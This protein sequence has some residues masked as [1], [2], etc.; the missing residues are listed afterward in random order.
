MEVVQG[1]TIAKVD[2]DR[3]KA[4]LLESHMTR[5]ELAKVLGIS[6]GTLDQKIIGT[7]KWQLDEITT[8]VKIFNKPFEFFLH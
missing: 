7:R 1:K 3:V 2:G 6:K 8:L 4:A 5:G